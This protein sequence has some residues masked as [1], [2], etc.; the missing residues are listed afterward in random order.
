MRKNLAYVL[1]TAL[2]FI[3][4]AASSAN[5]IIYNDNRVKVGAEG[6]NPLGQLLVGVYSQI[7]FDYDSV[8]NRFLDIDIRN[9]RYVAWWCLTC[10]AEI[11]S[12]TTQVDPQLRLYDRAT[13]RLGS[14]NAEFTG[15]NE[16]EVERE[17]W[18]DDDW[19]EIDYWVYIDGSGTYGDIIQGIASEVLPIIIQ[20][21][22]RNR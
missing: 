13:W 19:L 16:I 1:D 14:W 5:A 17:Y 21:I 4:V 8:D 12:T 18:I 7:E 9:W 10:Y 3:I 2:I 11:T 15:Y 6:Y 20:F 22:I